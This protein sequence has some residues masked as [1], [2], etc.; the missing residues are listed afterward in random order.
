MFKLPWIFIPLSI[1]YVILILIL[2]I[3]IIINY[4]I[5]KFEKQIQ[6]DMNKIC[7]NS[8]GPIG[9]IIPFSNIFQFD[10]QNASS[11]LNLNFAISVWSGCQKP[12]PTI[13]SFDIVKTFEG[14]DYSAKKN[15]NIAALYYSKPLNMAII[16]FSG[17]MY[18]T[19]WAN[20]FD[21]TQTNPTDISNNKDILIHKKQY[22]MYDTFRTD[23]I[24]SL[25]K[26]KDK[27]TIL[28][29]TGHSLGGA[30]ATICY[31]DVISN[32]VI[33]KGYRTLYTFGAPRVGN[34]AFTNIINDEKTQ[35]RVVN[36]E[37]IIPD[38]PL[39]IYGDKIYQQTN[40]TNDTIFSLNLGEYGL[41]HIDSYIKFLQY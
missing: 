37:D 18:L 25:N 9:P 32:N 20:D 4:I 41:N 24:S 6:V 23:F 10:R 12:L 31:L 28:V 13:Q 14:Y 15:R 8:I 33:P 21:F 38:I 22:I 29:V 7:T 17:T 16:S 40:T 34:I 1:I 36:T 30:L 3:I 5:N 19:E 26:I 39:P 2:L 27:D 35:F 11:F